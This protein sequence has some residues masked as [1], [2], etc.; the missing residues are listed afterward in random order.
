MATLPTGMVSLIASFFLL[1][2]GMKAALF[3]LFSWLPISYPTPPVSLSA[4]FAGLLTKVGVYALIRVFG[5][6]FIHDLGYTHTILIW[7]AA[8]TILIGVLSA[9]IQDDIRRILAFHLIAQVGFMVLGLALFSP[10]GLQATIFYFIEDIIVM[11]NL[12]LLTG[13]MAQHGGSFSLRRLGNL[14][15]EKSLLSL[16]F[17]LSAFSLAGIPPLSGFWAKLFILEA[18][19]AEGRYALV[20]IILIGAFLTLYSM[21]RLWQEGFW[22]GGQKSKN[23]KAQE[24]RSSYLPIIALSLITLWI[25]F[26]PQPFY[27]MAGHISQGILAPESYLNAVL[28]VPVEPLVDKA[29]EGDH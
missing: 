10:L 11:T 26:N 17:I 24:W 13:L 5:M 8:L 4:I 21:G 9:I 23:L 29:K 2:F 16:L 25:S 28:H 12:F 18:S 3:P 14:Y 27:R 15:Q 22:K 20:A 1:A 7:L 6:V 19:L